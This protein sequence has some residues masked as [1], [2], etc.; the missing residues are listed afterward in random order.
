MQ[1]DDSHEYVLYID[2]AGDD[3]LKNLR[4]EFPNGNSEWLVLAGYMVRREVDQDLPDLLR[5]IMNDIDARQ[6]RSLHY[7]DLSPRKRQRVCEI[8]GEKPARAFVVCSYK[9]TMVG[10]N[11]PRAAASSVPTKQY[12]YNYL[13]RLLLERATDYCFNDSDE[14]YGKPKKLKVVFAAKG[15]H[16]YGRTKAYIEKLKRQ[17]IAQSTV[18][19]RRVVRPEVLR[20]NL[21]EYLPTHLQAGLQMSDIIASAFFQAVETNRDT[22][23]CSP[24]KALHRIVAREI[25][26]KEHRL[27]Y[28][29]YGVT[30]VPQPYKVSL[31]DDQRKIFEIYGYVF[32]N[33]WS[34]R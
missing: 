32:D 9:R 19:N 20:F 6:A 16:Q 31:S 26:A 7:R 15:G 4:P 10:H 30:L 21:I 18:L 33:R 12:Y 14:R 11:N 1:D 22:W 23:T 2:E 29:D 8:L 24:A 27:V 34:F 3:V 17:A 5:M 28:P 13:I 25:V